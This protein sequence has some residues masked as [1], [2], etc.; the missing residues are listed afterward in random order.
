MIDFHLRLPDE[1]HPKVNDAAHDQRQS[2]NTFIVDT[3]RDK[4]EQ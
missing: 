1:L 4:V 2:M 3:L